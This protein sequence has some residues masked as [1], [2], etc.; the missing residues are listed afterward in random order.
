MKSA[1]AP[2]QA[3]LRAEERGPHS[4][5]PKQFARR[6]FEPA[7][8]A[9]RRAV[10]GRASSFARSVHVRFVYVQTARLMLG[11]S[12]GPAAS[13]IGSASISSPFA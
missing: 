2:V 7:R 10:R 12:P 13:V 8:F 4:A 11:Q 3:R 6:S 5:S 1:R 9:S